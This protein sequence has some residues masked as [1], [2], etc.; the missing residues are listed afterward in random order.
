MT[1]FKKS[2]TIKAP[3]EKVF[4]YITNPVNRVEWLRRVVDVRNITGQGKGQKWHYTYKMPGKTINGEVEVTEYIPNQRYAHKSSKGF[5]KAWTYEF[6]E[7]SGN[8]HLNI[9]V[10]TVSFKIPLIG[11]T[12]EKQMLRQSSRE[13]DQAVV[14]IKRVLES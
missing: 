14:N 13:A 5:A 8:T 6:S 2:T 4:N 1:I 11:R 12:I 9:L 10:E 3:V 7:E